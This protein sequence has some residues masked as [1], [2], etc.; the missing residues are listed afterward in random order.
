MKIPI[1]IASAGILHLDRS[2]EWEVTPDNADDTIRLDVHFRDPHFDPRMRELTGRDPKVKAK[3]L[4][5]AGITDIIEGAKAG[6]VARIYGALGT[7]LMDRDPL[8]RITCL[9]LCK[10]GRH[11]APVAADVLHQELARNPMVRRYADLRRAV[12]QTIDYP[13]ATRT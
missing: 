1:T 3:V 8:A 9:F 5:T 13:V 7:D 4:A 12:H 2:H 10:G 6:V 11:R